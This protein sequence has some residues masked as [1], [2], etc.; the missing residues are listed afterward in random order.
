M[1]LKLNKEESLNN[2]S[3]ACLIMNVAF[4]SVSKALFFFSK[5]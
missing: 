3:V 4:W 5:Q 2:I 1:Q